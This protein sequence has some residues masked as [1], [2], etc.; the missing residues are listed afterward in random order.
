LETTDR[1]VRITFRGDLDISRYNEVVQALQL[2]MDADARPVLIVLDET[3]HFADSF[4][5]S[6]LL[7]FRRRLQSKSRRVAVYCLNAT[8]YHTLALTKLAERLNVS[9][10]EADALKALGA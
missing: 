9:M 1:V 6:E 10:N 2:A 3:V 5:L 7:L 4:T 8:V